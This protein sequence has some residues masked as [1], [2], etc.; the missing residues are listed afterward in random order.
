MPRAAISCGSIA[1]RS[2]RST[3]SRPPLANANAASSSM[4]NTSSSPRGTLSSSGW[5]PAPAGAC[6]RAIAAASLRAEF[7]RAGRGQ[8]HGRRGS[9]CQVAGFGCYV[10]G[11]DA[12]NARSCARRNDPETGWPGYDTWGGA[13]DGK[14]WMTGVWGQ[15]TYDPELDLVFLRIERSRTRLRG[16][17]RNDRCED[18]RHKH[19]LG[20]HPENRPGCVE[21]SNLAADN[22]DQECPS[23]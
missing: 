23:R 15:L 1:I 11:H 21:A 4:A 8:R 22:W 19:A 9:S 2:R 14:R 16:P 5:M 6:G 10:T 3:S 7:Q 12:K 20:C 17:A 13:A 18:G